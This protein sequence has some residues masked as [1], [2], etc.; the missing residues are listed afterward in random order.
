VRKGYKFEH[1]LNKVIEYINN[2]G[3]HAHKNHPKRTVDGTYLEGEPF[4]YEVVLPNYK[5]VF[6]AKECESVAYSIAKKDLAQIENLKHCKNAGMN[7][8]LLIY[9]KG[10]GVKQFEIDSVIE[11]LKN[12]KKSMPYSQGQEWEL[13]EILKK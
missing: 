6:D 9:F 1:Q 5:A 13:L 11:I 7:A 12:G 8:Y 2:L 10:I 4:D 3:F